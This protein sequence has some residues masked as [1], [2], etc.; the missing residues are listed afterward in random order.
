M[1]KMTNKKVRTIADVQRLIER[2]KR[3]RENAFET[4]KAQTLAAQ[5]LGKPART[6]DALRHFQRTSTEAQLKFD[7]RARKFLRDL[8]KRFK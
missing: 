4:L 5:K 7:L 6:I 2:Q 1:I 8:P 3:E